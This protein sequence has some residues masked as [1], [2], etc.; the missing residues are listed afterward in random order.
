MPRSGSKASKPPPGRP[1]TPRDEVQ[2]RRSSRTKKM[3][4]EQHTYSSDEES[5][6]SSEDVYSSEEEE[7]QQTRRRAAP[8]PQ[9]E[10]SPAPVVSEARSNMSPAQ[11]KLLELVNK[12][13]DVNLQALQI[14]S[15]GGDGAGVLD[16][17]QIC[18]VGGQ[19]EGKS[20]LLSAIVSSRM[21][22]KMKFLPEGTGMVTRCPIE[23]QMT[24][25]G[26]VTEHTA[27]VRTQGQYGGGDSRT[28]EIA[29]PGANPSP[30]Q[31]DRWGHKI[32]KK[33]EEAQNDLVGPGAVTR[34]KVIVQLV[35]PCLPNLSLVDLPGLRAVDDPSTRG[36]KEELRAMVT[37]VVRSDNA[38]ILCASAAGTDPA[39]WVG[40]GLACEVDPAGTR[41]VGVVTKVDQLY[42][43]PDT[44]TMRDD[45][46]QLKQ[47]IARATETQY[48]AAYN[49]PAE[50]E[51]A[52]RRE[53]I[54]LKQEIESYFQKVRGCGPHCNSDV[55]VAQSRSCVAVCSKCT[56][57]CW[58]RR[59]RSR[60]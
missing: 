32:R 31:I 49:P 7:Q 15:D 41:T 11:L 39:T 46:A 20:T 4:R 38:I 55:V 37:D 2:Q 43:I 29:G 13:Q 1:M 47:E 57:A 59:H 58:K 53:G 14:A 5:T 22:S 25:P 3:Q 36:L 50:T 9:P 48:F 21:P 6:D 23:V 30:D 52:F 34:D 40:K 28:E 27:T 42:G 17:P 45:R 56:G 12:V 16:W 10:P 35:G 44:Q 8:T 19:A 54:S 51:Q 24:R 33:I 60:S 26:G 18:V